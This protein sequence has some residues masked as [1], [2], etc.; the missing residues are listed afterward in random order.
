MVLKIQ[1][2]QVDEEYIGKGLV[3]GS[4][5]QVNKERGENSTIFP[6]N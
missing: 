1:Y 2:L 5:G 3:E 4:N 6:L